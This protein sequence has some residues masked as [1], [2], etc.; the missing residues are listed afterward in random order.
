[1]SISSRIRHPQALLALTAVLAGLFTTQWTIQKARQVQPM[2]HL[3]LVALLPVFVSAL[4]LIWSRQVL[5]ERPSATSN[6]LTPDPAPLP[7]LGFAWITTLEEHGRTL[8][9]AASALLTWIN[10][11]WL[12]T[13]P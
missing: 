12:P 11:R 10:W 4:L 5:A 8:L 6:A 1:M 7:V 2:E 3:P 13:I 9:L